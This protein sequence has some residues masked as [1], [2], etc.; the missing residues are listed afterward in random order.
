MMVYNFISEPIKDSRNA[1]LDRSV[2][3]PELK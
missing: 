3:I 1:I 2:P